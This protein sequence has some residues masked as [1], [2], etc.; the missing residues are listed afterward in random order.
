M[1]LESLTAK[2]R[3]VR[4]P[5]SVDRILGDFKRPGQRERALGMAELVG[6]VAKCTT[7]GKV[8]NVFSTFFRNGKKPENHKR[9]TRMRTT[10]KVNGVHSFRG[11]YSAPRAALRVSQ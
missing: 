3:C 10:G 8:R 6:R 9:L 11:V 7:G 1:H 4:A 2:E 5:Q